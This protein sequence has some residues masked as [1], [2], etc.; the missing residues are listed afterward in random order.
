MNTLSKTS[1][2]FVKNVL[3]Y[4]GVSRSMSEFVVRQKITV[5]SSYCYLLANQHITD[6]LSESTKEHYE[7][8]FHACVMSG[9]YVMIQTEYSD[10]TTTN[11]LVKVEK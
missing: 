4:H 7:P 11:E 3:T 10:G 9:E 8:L 1:R 2:M 6:L 5:I